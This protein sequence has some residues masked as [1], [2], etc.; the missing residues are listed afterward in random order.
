MAESH[1]P[2]I[3]RA[4][5][6]ARHAR[7]LQTARR[8]GFVGRVE[9]RHVYTQSGGAQ[10][11]LAVAP[12]HDLLL[13][14]A[15]AFERDADSADFSL[16]AILAHERGHQLLARHQVLRRNLP[17]EWSG[18][19]EEIA[20]SLLGSLLVDST[21]DERNLLL[22]ALFDAGQHGLKQDD[23]TRLITEL[24]AVLERLL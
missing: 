9:Y 8:L 23:A 2:P 17:R 22:K 21:K 4:Q 24:Y 12:E 3:S 5:E 13:V 18:V 20:A 10:Y 16:E 1:P 14:S 11:G 7:V 15:E 6:K 19:S